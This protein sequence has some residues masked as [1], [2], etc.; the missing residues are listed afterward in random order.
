VACHTV[1]GTQLELMTFP[2]LTNWEISQVWLC[3]SEVALHFK[4]RHGDSAAPTRARSRSRNNIEPQS[5]M[6]QNISWFG[7]DQFR[8]ESIFLRWDRCT[9]LHGTVH[10]ILRKC[11]CAT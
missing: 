4:H 9:D 10:G 11:F 1:R 6:G 2:S 5:Q 3:S 7:C 8:W